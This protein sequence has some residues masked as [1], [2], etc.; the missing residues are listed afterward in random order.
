MKLGM[1]MG[2]YCSS[3]N[4]FQGSV[5]GAFRLNIKGLKIPFRKNSTSKN[6]PNVSHL[7][8][9]LYHAGDLRAILKMNFLGRA[10]EVFGVPN[11][12]VTAP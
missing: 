1:L 12:Q 2:I 6:S 5:A 8:F 11:I 9:N 3:I 7:V 10:C 4:I